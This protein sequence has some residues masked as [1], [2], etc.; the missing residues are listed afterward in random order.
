LLP[1]QTNCRA[2][3]R[4]ECNAKVIGDRLSAFAGPA[5]PSDRDDLFRSE[6]CSRLPLAARLAP[7]GHHVGG[8]VAVRSEEQ[9]GR[10]DALSIVAAMQHAEATRN[11]AADESPGHAVDNARTP[12]VERHLAV[13]LRVEKSGPLP[14]SAALPNVRPEAIGNRR[15]LDLFPA[16][17]R[18]S[19]ER[20]AVV[21]AAHRSLVGRQTASGNNA[22]RSHW[23]P[24][25]LREHSEMLPGASL[26]DVAECLLGYSKLAREFSAPLPGGSTR[27]NG[28]DLGVRNNAPCHSPDC[29]T[30]S[31]PGYGVRR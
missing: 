5:S 20:A 9:M 29:N 25:R 24:G 11:R 12:R 17:H 31:L 1:G 7:L 23:N 16:V 30:E 21:T 26:N 8:V 4:H 27:A 14:A 15:A 6:P 18:R 2:V 19:A 28:I 22:E 3:D 13:S 10:P